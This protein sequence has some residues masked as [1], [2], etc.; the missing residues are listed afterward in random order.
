MADVTEQLSAPLADRYRIARRLGAGGMATVYLAEDLK[1]DRKVALKVLRP[2]LAAVVG[3]DRFVQEI[4][5]TAQLQHPHI[6]PLYDSGSAA[7]ANG[8]AELL[9]YVMPYIHGE[10]LREKLDREVQ[11]GVDEAVRIA[12]EVADALQYA[13]EQ[14]VIHRDIK[15]ENILLHDGRAIVADFGIALAVSAAA[16]PRMTETGLSLGTPHYMSPEQ[17]TA[18]RHLTNR[19]DVYSLGSMLYEMLTGEPPHTGSSAQAIIMKIVTDEARPI[20][21]L[22]KSVPPHV[23]AAVARAV[24]KVPADRFDSA[25]A[26]ADALHDPSLARA[27]ARA[28]PPVR[29]R[30]VLALAAL[31][32]L[33]AALAAWGW[34][35]PGG[36][37]SVARY[38]TTL[39]AAGTPDGIALRVETALS[40]DGAF[41]VFRH[42]LKGPGQLYVKR[43]DEV[44]ARPLAGTE[45]G[46]GPFFSPDGAWIGFFA[47]GQMRR[48]P[49]GGG[50][51]LRLAESVDPTYNHGAWLADGSIYFYDIRTHTLRRLRADETAPQVVVAP[52]QLDGRYPWLPTPLPDARGILFTAHLTNCVGPVSCRPSRVYAYDARAD[53]IRALFD[54]AVGAWHVRTGHVLYLTSAGTLMA[55]PWDDDAL[56]AAGK[57]VPILDGIQAPGF[58]VSDEGTAMYLLGPPEFAPGPTP[59]AQLVWVDRRGQ[60]APVDSAWQVNTGGTYTGADLP[61]GWGIALSP[62]GRRV[63]LT[64]LTDL[65]TDVWIKAL[66]AGPVS[67]LTLH[68]G[69]DRAPAW[70]P[71]G[72]AITFL[73]DRPAPT[74]TTPRAG[75]LG[76]WE[77]PA[78]GTGEPRLLWGTDAPTDGF[79]SADRGW[80][81]LGAAGPSG[82][83]DG[84][85]ILAAKPGTD[86]AARRIVA[87]G[88]DEGGAALSP[89]SRWLAYVSNEQ[90]APE[91]FVRPF[92]D[93]SAG[94]W[95]VSS[96][97]GSAPVWSHDG[98]ELFYASGTHMYAVRVRPG[99]PFAAEPPRLLFAIPD[100]VRA[101]SPLRGTFALSPDD[102]R[103]LMVRDNDWEEMAGTRTLVVVEHFFEEL[104]A[105]LRK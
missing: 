93:V 37:R 100:R 39:G 28:G 82:A 47:N 62:D 49:S 2:E 59:N 13:H 25:R 103:F 69:E 56:A 84:G 78:D 63:A 16:G 3:A 85:D 52:P 70:T 91:V 36:T 46:S 30:V 45:G 8:G 64:L 61:V 31:V 105:K 27:T 87:T 24:E 11:L 50:T 89:D 73:S 79:V 35:R 74:G 72:R 34:L 9:Y 80:I 10:T 104:R 4:R 83:K 99:A 54:D 95:Q 21:E 67:R 22:R 77:Q 97:G 96:G 65:G 71:D 6:L 51:P 102:Q 58:V 81:V 38:Q 29:R 76:L 101:G 41:L 7:A 14:G 60:A 18:D 90:G 42:P 66:P 57:P 17:A 68:P 5:T 75:G 98:R 12:T 86:G 40:P 44:V 19:S 55:V 1:H 26:F 33:T 20:R 32:V 48:V 88:Y 15:P 23:A 94:R 92:P 43:R 53:T